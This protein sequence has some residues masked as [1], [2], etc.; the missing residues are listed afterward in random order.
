MWAARNGREDAVERLIAGGANIDATS[1]GGGT[2]L[3]FARQAGHE[4]IVEM[5]QAAGATH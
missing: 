1:E 3:S 4:Q 2:A 5:L